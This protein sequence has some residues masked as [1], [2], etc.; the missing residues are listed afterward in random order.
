[1]EVI[2]KLLMFAEEITLI[3]MKKFVILAAFFTFSFA[4]EFQE[5]GLEIQLD[6]DLADTFLSEFEEKLKSN[7]NGEIIAIC[8]EY[9]DKLFV[10]IGK[11]AV[12]HEL[13]PVP[14]P[15]MNEHF[16]GSSI[17]LSKGHL[18]GISTIKR[19]NDVKLSYQHSLKKLTMEL[20]IIFSNLNF[21]YHYHII[22]LLVG[23]EGG[24]TGKIEKFSIKINMEFDFNTYTA[25]AND[26]K[27][28]NSGSVDL[29]FD[30]QGIIDWALDI[31]SKFV[32]TILYPIILGVIEGITKGITNNIVD[33][34]NKLIDAII[35]HHSNVTTEAFY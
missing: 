30:G 29:T 23:P 17:S 10:D 14:L 1:M 25:K 16:L 8:N 22:L 24:M 2:S 27:T 19:Y 34:V 32:T 33:S 13:D 26:V 12:S 7:N 4:A 6:R 20:P 35:H 15:D 3:K 11:F 31:I 18:N 21:T 28:T 5:N 9:A